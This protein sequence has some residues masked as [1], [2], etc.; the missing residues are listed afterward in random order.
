ML[1]AGDVGGTK[2]LLG[3]FRTAVGRPEPVHVRTF[4][5][6]DFD[7]LE[8]VIGAFLESHV[9]RSLA[10]DAACFGVAGPIVENTA[11]LVNV[12][13]SVDGRAIAARFGIAPVVLLNDLAAMGYSVPVLER[14][15]LLVVHG[16]EPVRTGNAAVIAPGTG[17]G[18]ALLHNAGGMLVPSPSEGGHAD[19]SARTPREIELLQF[20]TALY[21]RADCESVISGRGLA[22]LFRFTHPTGQCPGLVDPGDSDGLAPHVTAS[23]LIGNCLRCVEALEIFM[24]ALGAEAGNLALRSVATR[25]IY[26]GGGIAPKILPAFQRPHFIEAFVAKGPMRD[27]LEKIPVAVILNREAALIGAA[28]RAQSLVSA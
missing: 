2:T 17:L 10:I 26:I 23:A 19:F 16:G 27:L 8:A 7:G 3:L 6:L 4:V 20:L 25:G 24:S 12:P 21:G 18:Q 11:R 13:W 22:N 5:T 14:T 1:L 28:V 9:E 15:E